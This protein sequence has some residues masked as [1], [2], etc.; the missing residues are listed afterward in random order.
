MKQKPVRVLD[1]ARSA[2]I[3]F[4]CGGTGGHL[5]QCVCRLLY[6]MKEKSRA[7]PGAP[8]P[9]GEPPPERLPEVLVC[10]GDTVERANVVRQPYLPQDVGKKKATVLAGRYAA[11]HDLK[12]HAYP[13][14][15]SAPEELPRLVPEGAVVVGCVDNAKTRRILH[16]GLSA[17]EDIVYLDSGNAGVVELPDG[18]GLLPRAERARIK[19]SGWEGQV[20]CG[21]R[22]SAASGRAGRPSSRSPRSRSPTSS[23]ATT[24][25]RTRFHAAGWWRACH[26]GT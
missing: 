14:Y 9:F 10:D 25:S 22:C 12:V 8:T 6:G 21:V 23:R 20:L 15:L 19:E 11:I 5:L 1:P 3:L 18:A 2:L 4:G 16:E 24:S 7:H 17:Y 13:E 26:S